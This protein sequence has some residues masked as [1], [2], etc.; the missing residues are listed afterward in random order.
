[1]LRLLG[2]TCCHGFQSSSALADHMQAEKLTAVELSNSR[3]QQNYVAARQELL[4]Q[5]EQVGRC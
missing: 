5:I 2:G 3:E 4:A 1:M